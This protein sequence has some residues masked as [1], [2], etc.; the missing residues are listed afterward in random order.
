M[1]DGRLFHEIL[2]EFTNAKT[3]EEKVSVLRK[4]DNNRLRDFFVMAYNPNIVFDVDIPSYRP[5]P[6]PEGLNWTHLEAEIPKLYRFIQGHPQKPNITREKAK[7][8]LVVILESLHKKEAEILVNLI[9]K[10]LKVKYLTP[11]IVQEAFP[12]IKLS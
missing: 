8:L 11:N 2:D 3:R 12:D 1:K 6:E 7:S 4:Y 10:D 9:Q 5:A